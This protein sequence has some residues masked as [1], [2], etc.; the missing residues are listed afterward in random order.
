MTIHTLFDL[1]EHIRRVVALNFQQPIWIAAEIAQLGQSRGH[2]YLQLVQKGEGDQLVAQS[3]AVLW[4]QDHRRLSKTLGAQLD[5][6]L[7]E[8]LE[9]KMY[10]RVD[11]HEQYGL[12]LHITDLDPAHTLGQLERQR[13]QT[14]QTLRQLNLLERNAALPL[15]VVLQRIAVVTSEGAAGW[16]DFREQLG[17]NALGYRF[18]C[19][20]FQAS[21]QGKNAEAELLASLAQVAARAADFDCV[22]VVRGGGARLDLAAFDGLEL[23]RQ[24]AQMPLPVLTGIGHDIDETVLDLVAHNAL[25]TPTAVAD[26]LIQHNLFFENELQRQAEQ[27]GLTGQYQLKIS[28]LEMERLEAS[29]R[30]GSRDQLQNAGRMLDRWAEQI[31]LLATRLLRGQEQQLSQIETL[32]A[33]LQPE[34]V[35]RRGYSRTLKNGKTLTNAAEVAPGDEL[36]TRLRNGVVKSKVT[37]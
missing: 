21:V 16:Q 35:L 4:A 15:P 24:V 3:A 1:N 27:I 7:Q 32:C 6:V 13:R 14:I 18:Q 9:V 8:G 26:F 19:Q 20:L 2:W 36:E 11:F 10:V 29:L 37:R 30:W 31:P 5:A 17:Q 33:A 12:K 25:K 28:A 22:V 23:S 34:N